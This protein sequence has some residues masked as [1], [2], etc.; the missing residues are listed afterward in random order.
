MV[1]SKIIDTFESKI[2][3]TITV[4]ENAGQKKVVAGGLIQSG[5]SI[6]SLWYK[7]LSSLKSQTFPQILILGLGAGTIARLTRNLWS[8]AQITG[9]EI[10]KQMIV[11][12]ENHFQL[13]S[14]PNLIVVHA[15]V[16]PWVSKSLNCYDLV[17]IDVFCGNQVV[18]KLYSETFI[19][20]L[21]KIL[22]QSGIVIVNQLFYNHYKEK[23]KKLVNSF[24]KHFNK[25]R[26]VRNFTNVFV[27]C[28]NPIT[29]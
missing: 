19:T 10:D 25:I 7:P 17:L 14:I 5:G 27:I 9:V 20:D 16:F 24:E 3:G 4:S 1:S 29:S 28:Q 22:N 26:L 8:N 13:R 6:N 12:G 21:K 2:S 11:I 23:A 18:E 15:D